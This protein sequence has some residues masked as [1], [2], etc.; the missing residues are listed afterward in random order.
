MDAHHKALRTLVLSVAV[1]FLQTYVERADAQARHNES[2]VPARIVSVIPAVTEMLFAV[3]AGPQ[4]VGVGSYDR[5]PSEVEKLPRVGALLDPDFE[6]ILSLRPDL[7]VVYATQTDFIERLSKASIPI[8]KYEHAGLADITTT[9]RQLGDRVGRTKN[10]EAVAS[11]IERD[12]DAVRA[13]VAA[14][15]A[16]KTLLIFGREPGS[17][18]GIYASGGVGFLHDLLVVAG[19]TDAFGD[20]KKQSI[21]ISSEQVIARAPEAVIELYGS[22]ATDARLAAERALWKHLPSVPAVR[23]NKIHL[24]RGDFLTSPGPRIAQAA[25][26]LADALHPR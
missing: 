24:L 5:F 7:V 18:R 16:I 3:G 4:V 8:F 17:L 14:R 10:A 21:V 11:G 12:L 9:I 1:L 22:A 13:R 2:A 15:P 20:V 19:G 26:A 25:R 23:N 6:K